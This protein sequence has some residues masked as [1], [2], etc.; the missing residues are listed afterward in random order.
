MQKTLLT[1]HS[2]LISILTKM[3]RS[4]GDKTMSESSSK[5]QT[6]AISKPIV[7]YCQLCHYHSVRFNIIIVFILYWTYSLIIVDL[8]LRFHFSTYNHVLLLV[9]NEEE[10]PSW[11]SIL[12]VYHNRFSFYSISSNSLGNL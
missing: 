9:K 1:V 8:T 10:I 5:D 2:V 6:Y 7:S 4:R 12:E 3:V 11:S